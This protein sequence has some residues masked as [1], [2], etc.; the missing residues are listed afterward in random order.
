MART[1]LGKKKDEEFILNI[2]GEDRKVRIIAIYDKYYSIVHRALTDV[3]EQGGNRIMRPIR[4]NSQ[5]TAEEVLQTIFEAAGVDTT[6]NVDA[7]LQ[8]NYNAQPSFLLNCRADDLLWSY[9]RFLFTDFKLCPWPT[10]LKDPDRFKFV[11]P[12]TLFVLDLSSLLILFEKTLDGDYKPSRRFIV[13]NYLYEY[14][15]DYK[16]RV[17]WKFS[18]DMHKVL[19]AG[20]IHRFSE[21][22]LEDIKLR[23]EALLKW[24][25]DY[26]ER[27]SSPKIL[28]CVKMPNETEATLLFKHNMTLLLDDLSRALLTE[29]W[30]YL[31]LLH[32][33]LFLFNCNEFFGI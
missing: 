29:D 15:R 3:M 25:D 20:K 22:P 17:G 26:C 2:V 10:D 9:Y 16:N 27:F 7:Q 1:M 6:I 18:Y 32:E 24:M 33:K 13:S 23:Y 4:I 8:N 19:E 28:E 31:V 21:D 30:Y 5:M 14:I 12:Q 11:T